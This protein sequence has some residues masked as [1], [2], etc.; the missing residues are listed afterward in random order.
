MLSIVTDPESDYVFVTDF[1]VLKEH[2]DNLLEQACRTVTTVSLPSPGPDP[3][4]STL[5]FCTYFFSG[6]L[7]KAANTYCYFREIVPVFYRILHFRHSAVNCIKIFFGMAAV[8]LLS[9]MH[10]M[11]CRSNVSTI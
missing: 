11:Q 5:R 7:N 8:Y 3:V 6:V 10:A 1:D 4:D 2:L 9:T